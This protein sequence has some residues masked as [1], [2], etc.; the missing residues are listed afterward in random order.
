MAPGRGIFHPRAR[1]ATSSNN[2]VKPDA[3]LDGVGNRKEKIMSS[4]WRS[5]LLFIAIV[6]VLG[7]LGS[8]FFAAH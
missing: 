6:V 2:P 5:I 8:V 3:C 4:I 1:A 7:A